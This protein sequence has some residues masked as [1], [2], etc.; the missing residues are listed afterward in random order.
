LLLQ[1]LEAAAVIQG[2]DTL[3]LDEVTAALVLHACD[4]AC[5]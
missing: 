4:H 5:D 1:V 3:Q 2:S